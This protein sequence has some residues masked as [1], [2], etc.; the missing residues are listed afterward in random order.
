MLAAALVLGAV[1]VALAWPV[2]VALAKAE[3]PARAPA[4]ALML[5]QGI[6]LGGA[7]AMI[8][9]LLAFAAVPAGSL[10]AAA[11]HLMPALLHGAIPPEYAVI[12]LAALT[13]AFGL[14]LHLALN[15]GQTA[16][17]AERER[18]RQHEL[19]AVLGDP[20]P[21]V[22][23]TLVLAH[24]EP[25]A[26]CVPGLRTATVL[27]DGLVDALRPDELAA[28]I[29]HERAHLDQFH[30]L[31]LLSFRAWHSALPWFPIANR[32]ERAVSLLTEM[33]ADDTARRQVGDASLG[34]A[35]VLVGA[36]GEP[37][38]Y[39]DSGGVSPDREMLDARL[40]RLG[41]SR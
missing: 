10:A 5:W 4:R 21:G 13:L 40:A 12:H 34:A 22:P 26:Y 11:E 30:H 17:R 33:L 8:G 32:A 41:I 20:M 2:P 1:A 19:V 9:A 16:V 31:V 15:L 39:A 6:A 14:V 29:A 3:W 25:F 28:V 7:F 27:T 23:R 38:A 24:P 18:R 35:M 36:S 37:G